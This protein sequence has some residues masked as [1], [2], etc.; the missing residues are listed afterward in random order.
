M[1]ASELASGAKCN[2]I[3]WTVMKTSLGEML[4]AATERGI[5]CLAF[6]E[7]EAEL[8]TRFPHAHLVPASEEFGALFDQVLA[9]VERPGPAAAAIP[10][11]VHGTVFQTRV[12][13]ELRR[14]PL[15]ETRSYGEL[16]AMLGSPGASRAVGG[17][18][19]A[20]RIAVL[21]PCHRVIAA[22]GSVGGYAYGEAIKRELLRREREA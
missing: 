22:D 11:D 17:A 13:D 3:H 20:N 1:K 21:I 9:A 16:A 12:W 10:L 19:R 18:N 14:I 6:G 7:G 4:V 15:G 8:A 5:A 2:V